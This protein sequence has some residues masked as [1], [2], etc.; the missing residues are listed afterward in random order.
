MGAQQS[1]LMN[2]S[3]FRA[4][5]AG[6]IERDMDESS[7][8]WW[9]R[10]NERWT[11][12]ESLLAAGALI[13]ARSRA[14]VTERLGFTCSAGVAANKLL[15]KLCGGLHKPNQQTVLSP[16]AVAELLDPLPVDRLRGFGG[17]LG[18]LLKS[19]RPDLGLPGFDSIGA[20]R[21][22]GE[23]AVS[24]VLH[25]PAGWANPEATA[26]VACRMASGQDD[27]PVEE[28]PLSK[29]VGAGKNFSGARDRARGPLDTS[30]T[31][32]RWVRELSQDICARLGEEEELNQRSATQLIVSAGLEGIGASRSKRCSL[33]P[34]VVAMTADA[35]GILRQLTAGRP[36]NRLGV[37]GLSLTAEGFVVSG[38]REERGALQRM[39]QK[40][41]A[42]MPQHVESLELA[43]SSTV[44]LLPQPPAKR[45]CPAPLRAGLLQRMFTQGAAK[46]QDVRAAD[47]TSGNSE[48]RLSHVKVIDLSD[49]EDAVPQWACSACTFLNTSEVDRCEVC[50]TARLADQ[51]LD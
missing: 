28:R 35:M 18:E 19:G 23:A 42:L 6:Q 50:E 38:S 14:A 31:L 32:E 1:G 48:A 41:A 30:D 17:K 16:A 46:A 26:A 47:K 39:F 21:L 11:P 29:Q 49:E 20:L 34:G 2:R 22:A 10:G 24:K 13:V 5:H 33:R 25:G 9:S 7:R 36:S 51:A 8:E 3:A 37:T 45:P 40:N 12:E 44:E 43:G 27:A 4:G 15:A